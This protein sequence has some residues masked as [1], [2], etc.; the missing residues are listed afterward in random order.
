M[1]YDTH[2][3]AAACSSGAREPQSRKGLFAAAANSPFLLPLQSLPYGLTVTRSL[4]TS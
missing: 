4:M 3:V 2:C 1:P